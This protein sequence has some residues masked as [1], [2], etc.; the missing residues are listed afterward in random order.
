M[1]L[2]GSKRFGTIVGRKKPLSFRG[3]GGFR[4]VRQL[5]TPQCC[6]NWPLPAL[7]ACFLPCS[8]L[9][10]RH[11]AAAGRAKVWPGLGPSS[12][13]MAGLRL[14]R[15]AG[16]RASLPS[17]GIFSVPF[18]AGATGPPSSPFRGLDMAALP[19]RF[20]AFFGLFPCLER[21]APL[22]DFGRTPSL[23]AALLRH[24]GEFSSARPAANP[25]C[26]NHQLP[27]VWHLP[28]AR[29]LADS[30]VFPQCRTGAGTLPTHH[31]FFDFLLLLVPAPAS[32]RRAASS[33]V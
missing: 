19:F 11:S 26:G 30:P 25:V 4:P 28:A 13:P 7:T 12:R 29:F 2:G 33:P 8:S 6:L 3:K 27:A 24:A 31:V 15:F 23:A 21:P 22:R 1:V 16:N 32:P 17:A 20:A 9:L 5:Q 14:P 18:C 10:F